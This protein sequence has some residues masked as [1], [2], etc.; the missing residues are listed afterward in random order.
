[1]S[2][3]LFSAVLFLLIISCNDQVNGPGAK[4]DSVASAKTSAPAPY[5]YITKSTYSSQFELGDP[6]QADIV[7]TL[8]KLFDANNLD[9]GLNYYADTVELW[10]NDGWK[11][12][13]PKDSLMDIMKRLR[14][15]YTAVKTDVA[16]IIPLRI[17]DRDENWVCIYGTE[18]LTIKNKVDSA[19][20]Q[21]NWRFNKEGKINMM[22]AYK[23]SK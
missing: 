5:E 6:K 21:E 7:F 14:G 19:D 10:T 17:I 4:G 22:H 1:M 15:V 12:R 20:I 2:N 9:Q 8:W 11:Y 3:P 13:G 16:A 23:R 18:Y